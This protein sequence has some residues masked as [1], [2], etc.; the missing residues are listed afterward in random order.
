MIY[1]NRILTLLSMQGNLILSVRKK[2]ILFKKQ[3]NFYFT[4]KDMDSCF[5]L[6]SPGAGCGMTVTAVFQVCHSW[7]DQESRM[8]KSMVAPQSAVI[9]RS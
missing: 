7:L 1:A 6:L 4:V 5:P 8:R 3:G 2:S 9:A